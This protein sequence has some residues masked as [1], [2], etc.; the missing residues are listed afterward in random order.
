M[1]KFSIVIHGGAGTILRENLTAE[2]ELQY[3]NGL[4]DSL[5]AGYQVLYK[6][7]SAFEAVIE[8]VRKLEDNPLFNAGRGSVFS[9]NGKNEMDA[10]VMDGTLLKAGAV[11][12]VSNIRNPVELAATVMHHTE[13][14]LLSGLGA[15]DLALKHGIAIEPDEYFYSEYRYKQWKSARDTESTLLDHTVIQTKDTLKEKKFGTV[16][17]VACDINGHLAAATSTGGMTNKKFGRIGD[18][19]IVG[20]GTYANNN[21]CAISC[22][23]HGEMFLL[24]VAA[25]DVSCLMEYKNLTLEEAMNIVVND[26]L[27]KLKGEGGMIGVDAKGN[28]GMIFNTPGMYRG[29]RTSAGEMEIGIYL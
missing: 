14:V 28:Y 18:S 1:G 13:H 11:A 16:G 15:F 23:G 29:V 8:A 12:G 2:L 5:N 4:E 3:R 25:Y 24:S 21:T 22:T 9:S 10:A 26:K 27:V 7:G 19:P 6:G 20:A 17:A